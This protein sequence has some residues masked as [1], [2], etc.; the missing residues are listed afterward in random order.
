MPLK[1]NVPIALTQ[2]DSWEIADLQINPYAPSVAY[3][4]VARLDG[5]EVDR[6]TVNVHGDEL[7]NSPEMLQ[8]Y[9]VIKNMVYA[10]AQARGVIPAEAVEEPTAQP[11]IDSPADVP[12]DGE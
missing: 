4:I 2:A 7:M 1:T 6:K 5:V 9:E 11:I 12:A 10:D 3:Q 8:L